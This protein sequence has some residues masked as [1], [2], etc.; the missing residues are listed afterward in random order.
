MLERRGS[1]DTIWLA[2]WKTLGSEPGKQTS[3]PIYDGGGGEPY[4]ET[5]EQFPEGSYRPPVRSPDL[6]MRLETT[7]MPMV[8]CWSSRQSKRS[9]PQPQRKGAQP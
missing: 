6:S 8:R 1:A 2:I 7:E 3:E 9:K 4:I 5:R